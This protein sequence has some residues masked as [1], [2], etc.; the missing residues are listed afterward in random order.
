MGLL[1]IN[2]QLCYQYSIPNGIP[3][4]WIIIQFKQFQNT[5]LERAIGREEKKDEE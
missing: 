1:S 4:P 3:I 5:I 2:F